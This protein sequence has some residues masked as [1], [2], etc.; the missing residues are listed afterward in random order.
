VSLV[1]LSPPGACVIVCSIDN[2]RRY[3]LT[4]RPVPDLNVHRQRR[5]P[6]RFPKGQVTFVFSSC[7]IRC[8]YTSGFYNGF[9]LWRI[10]SS[11]KSY[12][13]WCSKDSIRQI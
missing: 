8:P 3:N 2:G 9:G 1:R 7:I 13:V 5:H 10:K 6:I 4:V 12:R 11:K